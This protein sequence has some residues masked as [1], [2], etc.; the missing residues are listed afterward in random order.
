MRH[1]PE[2][3]AVGCLGLLQHR[4]RERRAFA[5][6]RRPADRSVLKLELQPEGALGGSQHRQRRGRDLRPDAV[7]FQNQNIECVHRHGI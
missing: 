4:R 2:Q 3:H 6:V 1:R 7:A 5:L